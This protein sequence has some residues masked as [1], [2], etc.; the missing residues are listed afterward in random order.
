MIMCFLSLQT[1]KPLDTLPII[2]FKCDYMYKNNTHHFWFWKVYVNQ[3]VSRR[4]E[5]RF[6]GEQCSFVGNV[7]KS[8]N[9][10]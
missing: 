5:I 8:K 1:V 10:C 6:E 4:F 9:N 3:L 2:C 7:L